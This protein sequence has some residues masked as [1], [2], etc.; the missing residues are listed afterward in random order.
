MRLEIKLPTV[1]TFVEPSM[2]LQLDA[3]SR[4]NFYSIHTSSMRE[5]VRAVREGPASTVLFSAR[6]VLT[7]QMLGVE[8]LVRNFPAI[9]TVAVISSSERLEAGKI[10]ELGVSGVRQLVDLCDRS[11]WDKLRSIV[12]QPLD[13]AVARVVTAIIPA[14][15]EPSHQSRSFFEALIRVAPE[16]TTVRSLCRVL[17][18]HPSTMMSRFLRAGLPS[19]RQYLS[20]ARLVHAAGLLED[21]GLSLADVAYRLDHSSPQSFGRHV[22]LLMGCTAN[23]Y[24]NTYD[25]DKTA[26]MFL[27][28]MVTPYRYVFNTF[29][30][31]PTGV[32]PGQRRC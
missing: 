27:K 15:E 22:K 20:W 25:F 29:E 6:H 11:G 10:L 12:S 28:K 32:F 17:S 5:V 8:D 13:T 18:V 4:G 26:D 19:P 14:L 23:Q 30:P 31:L 21:K 16:T 7:S 1:A 3:A 9:S 24:R 2:Q